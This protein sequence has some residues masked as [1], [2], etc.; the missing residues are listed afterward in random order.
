MVCKLCLSWSP[1]YIFQALIFYHFD[2]LYLRERCE[3]TKG[4]IIARTSNMIRQY[5]N[6]MK[7]NKQWSTKHYTEN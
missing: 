4:V 2:I 5:N 3:D 1:F 6:Q 7:T